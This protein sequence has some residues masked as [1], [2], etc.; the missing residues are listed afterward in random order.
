MGIF[1]KTFFRL[2]SEDVTAATAFGPAAT[3]ATGGQFPANNSAG[4]SPGDNRPINPYKAILGSSKKKGKKGKKKVP[5]Q[6]RNF[7]PM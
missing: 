7:V 4:F 2:I 6:R 1:A 5:Y 3:G